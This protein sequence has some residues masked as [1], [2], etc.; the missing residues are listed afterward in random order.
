MC[1]KVAEELYR[2]KNITVGLNNPYFIIN[3]ARTGIHIKFWDIKKQSTVE[4]SVKINS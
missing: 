3:V 1:W 2:P 4:I